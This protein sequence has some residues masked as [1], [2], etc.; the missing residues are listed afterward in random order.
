VIRQSVF[1]LSLL[2]SYRAEDYFSCGSNARAQAQLMAR[3]WPGGRMLL[4]GPGGAGKT[5]LAH[6]WAASAGAQMVAAA[7]LG[8]ADLGRLSGALVIEDAED[9]AGDPSAE[10]ALFH[11]W[12][13]AETLLITAA[14]PPRD[15]GL[16]LPDLVSRV[17]S[18]V[19]AQLDAPD[20]AL[21][22]AVLVKLFADRQIQ[23]QPNLIAFLLPRMERSVAAARQI[24]ADLDARS[25]ALGKPI[26]R[27]FAA[28]FLRDDGTLDRIGPG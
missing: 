2:Q 25:L 4:I 20:D 1:D 22:S 17:Q 27:A 11:L 12:N 28:E 6:I 24:V 7:D 15:W 19:I 16:A 5:H 10:A 13:R 18:M 9:L 21:L 26:T 8:N 23:V 3:D 14:A